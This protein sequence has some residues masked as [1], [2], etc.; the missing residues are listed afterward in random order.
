MTVPEMIKARLAE[1]NMTQ[2]ALADKIGTTRQNFSNK[3]TR[4]SFSM[5]ELSEICRALG[6]KLVLKDGGRDVY[7]LDYSVSQK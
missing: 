3:M 6:L 5:S 1:M 7:D 2:S 4:D